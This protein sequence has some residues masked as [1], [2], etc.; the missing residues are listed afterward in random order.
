MKITKKTRKVHKLGSSTKVG[1]RSK[2]QKRTDDLRDTSESTSNSNSDSS[3]DSSSDSGSDSSSESDS[4][5]NN[6]S[7]HVFKYKQK[8]YGEVCTLI[9]IINVFDYMEDQESVEK[10]LPYL[11]EDKWQEFINKSGVCRGYT[12]KAVTQLI[13]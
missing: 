11:D 2:K 4:N 5:S 6:D 10:L 12:M 9:N 1:L 7:G 13:W 3:S 8:T